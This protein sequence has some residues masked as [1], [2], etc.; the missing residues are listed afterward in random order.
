[1]PLLDTGEDVAQEIVLTVCGEPRVNRVTPGT[2]WRWIAPSAHHSIRS[3]RRS[4]SRCR[5]TGGPRR[6]IASGAERLRRGIA[7]G[8][9]K[10]ELPRGFQAGRRF[11]WWI[12]RLRRLGKRRQRA[13]EN[14]VR[15]CL[16]DGVGIYLSCKSN[17]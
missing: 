10:R 6:E 5:S 17:Q 4:P 12:G 1:M 2:P 16:T 13:N 11:G 9:E 14:H 15:L 8:R 7:A 3:A